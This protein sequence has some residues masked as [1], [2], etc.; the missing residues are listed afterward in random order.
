MVNIIGQNVKYKNGEIFS[1]LNQTDEQHVTLSNGK[2]YSYC[3]MFSSGT[4]V[5]LDDAIQSEVMKDIVNVQK[6]TELLKKQD[7]YEQNRQKTCGILDDLKNGL[8]SGRNI[9]HSHGDFR[10]VEKNGFEYYKIY[11]KKHLIYI[12]TAAST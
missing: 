5:L 8:F 4:F 12:K 10:D 6:V 9:S 11:G 3:K 7:E 1:V 2:T